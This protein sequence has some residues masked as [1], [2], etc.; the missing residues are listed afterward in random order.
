MKYFESSRNFFNIPVIELYFDLWSGVKISFPLCNETLFSYYIFLSV[1]T[2]FFTRFR[3][4][5]YSYK[6]SFGTCF[7]FT[8]NQSYIP[9]IS[10]EGRSQSRNTDIISMRK[11]RRGR[12][13]EEGK[14]KIR[15]GRKNI[16]R[17]SKKEKKREKKKK[18]REIR[19][20]EWTNFLIRAK[21]RDHTPKSRCP[22]AIS[23]RSAQIL[24]SHRVRS[25]TTH[26]S[27]L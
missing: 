14:K 25:H 17:I 4:L 16:C 27:F 2:R 8:E 24:G 7:S 23:P 5:Y 13:E 3:I 20:H 10:E 15:R 1:I 9:R 26:P 11:G 18:I 6:C 22:S 12:Q 21:Q 19:C